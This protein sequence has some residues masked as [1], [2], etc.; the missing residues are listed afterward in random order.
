MIYRVI[1]LIRTAPHK[2]QK[3]GFEI[4]EPPQVSEVRQI[5]QEKQAGAECRHLT[6]NIHEHNNYTFMTH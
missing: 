1:R 3:G 5:P 2:F 4:K 6:K